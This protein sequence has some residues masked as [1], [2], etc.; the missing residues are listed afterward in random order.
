MKP[1]K[2]SKFTQQQLVFIVEAALVS[3][4]DGIESG[5]PTSIGSVEERKNLDPHRKGESIHMLNMYELGTLE[6][7]GMFLSV[8]YAQL[9]DDGMGSYD[10]L[11]CADDFHLAAEAWVN[12]AWKDE[13]K[14]VFKK[15]K[16]LGT[17]GFQIKDAYTNYPN[18]RKHAEAFVD[19]AF[20]DYLSPSNE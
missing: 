8:L 15:L 20:S 11:V 19:R 6:T 16:S 3:C 12:K 17:S 18:C 4:V 14:R 7:T 10:A 5:M 2:G 9:T 1:Y 13:G